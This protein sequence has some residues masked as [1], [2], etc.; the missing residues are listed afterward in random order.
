[1]EINS[2]GIDAFLKF[3]NNEKVGEDAG[4]SQANVAKLSEGGNVK[5]YMI[6][7]SADESHAARYQLMS[8]V[9]QAFGEDKSDVYQAIREKLLGTR[10]GDGNAAIVNTK[11]KKRDIQQVIG[12][13]TSSI[14]N[15]GVNEVLDRS[16]S[17]FMLKVYDEHEDGI[18]LKEADEYGQKISDKMNLL[19][20]FVIKKLAVPDNKALSQSDIAKIAEKVKSLA[21]ELRKKSAEAFV[22]MNA[23]ELADLVDDKVTKLVIEEQPTVDQQEGKE[24]NFEQEEE[25]FKNGPQHG[26]QPDGQPKA[27][28][29]NNAQPQQ[30]DGSALVDGNAPVEGGQKVE[31][32]DPAPKL[33]PQAAAAKATLTKIARY[34][35]ADNPDQ[36]TGYLGYLSANDYGVPVEFFADAKSATAFNANSQVS[37][38][39]RNNANAAAELLKNKILKSAEDLGIKGDA[40]EAVKDQLT[41]EEVNGLMLLSRANVAKA[42]SLIAGDSVATL[43]ENFAEGVESV[44]PFTDTSLAKALEMAKHLRNSGFDMVVEKAKTDK[45][46][47]DAY[48]TAFTDFVHS[49]IHDPDMLI[50]LKVLGEEMIVPSAGEVIDPYDMSNICEQNPYSSKIG[51]TSDLAYD[52][53]GLPENGVTVMLNFADAS[54]VAGYF[55]AYNTQEERV[56]R[57]FSPIT[58]AMLIATGQATWDNKPDEKGN[59]YKIGYKSEYGAI[60][61]VNGFCVKGYLRGSDGNVRPVVMLFGASLSVTKDGVSSDF[62]GN[63][64][65]ANMYHLEVLKDAGLRKVFLSKPADPRAEQMMKNSREFFSLYWDRLN[66]LKLDYNTFRQLMKL[67]IF[68]PRNGKFDIYADNVEKQVDNFCKFIGLDRIKQHVAATEEKRNTLAEMELSL[69][70]LHSRINKAYANAAE[71]LSTLRQLSEANLRLGSLN[72]APNRDNVAINQ[73]LG[74]IIELNNKC[75]E[76]GL[77]PVNQAAVVADIEKLEKY[78]PDG[79]TNLEAERNRLTAEIQGLQQAVDFLSQMPDLKSA[80]QNAHMNY[81]ETLKHSYFKWMSEIEGVS[82]GAPVNL[83]GGAIGSGAFSNSMYEI[84][85][86]F[87]EMLVLKGGACSGKER[88]KVFKMLFADYKGTFK[89]L[90]FRAAFV[91][92]CA[93]YGV[94]WWTEEDKYSMTL[95]EADEILSE[96][97]NEPQA[98]LDYGRTTYY[99][100]LKDYYVNKY[101]GVNPKRCDETDKAVLERWQRE[102]LEGMEKLEDSKQHVAELRERQEKFNQQLP[103]LL[104]PG[105]IG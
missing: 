19:R 69:R 78:G 63:S 56:V 52:S 50:Q 82:D 43:G 100:Q 2:I 9:N 54:K 103:K 58:L 90:V 37:A 44:E 96:Y 88:D 26:Q 5:E 14:L 28:E 71:R 38:D 42:V 89:E 91:K 22:N 80:M 60:S 101:E 48:K 97:R 16:A 47:S 12:M 102:R 25:I 104:N 79:V 70:Q 53:A 86:P 34:V 18:A 10:D 11:L 92:A 13:T 98:D 76:L 57:R 95:Q 55:H 6:K 94:P 36:L 85:E 84:F 3:A 33:A 65:F 30:V 27:N 39:E 66:A 64:K 32:G 41:F 15:K 74:R 46:D 8:F 72:E 45:F 21:E 31:A 83:A 40:L 20:N 81:L 4:F 77:K 68:S 73:V 49:C 87:A 61:S 17:S 1:M 24:E 59:L 67:A 75:A 7:P 51:G 23:D 99:A 93:T 105:L 29:V 35:K 62:I